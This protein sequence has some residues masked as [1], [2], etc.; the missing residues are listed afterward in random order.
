MSR[1]G[2]EA[3]EDC[4]GHGGGA[5]AGK[6][7]S[8]GGETGG[9][10]ETANRQAETGCPEVERLSRLEHST[11]SEGISV[12]AV[13]LALTTA[14][15]MGV[16]FPTPIYWGMLQGV[17]ATGCISTFLAMWVIR[18]MRTRAHQLHQLTRGHRDTHPCIRGHRCAGE[19]GRRDQEAGGE[20]GR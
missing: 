12:W 4:R 5:P 16:E 19:A 13:S 3:P 18:R 11:A 10:E 9:G 7:H 8:D 6:Q 14:N 15:I 1:P 17:T 20:D 2:G